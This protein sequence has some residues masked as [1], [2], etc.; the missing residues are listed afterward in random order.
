MKIQ[1]FN[2]YGKEETVNFVYIYK[3]CAR[4][5]VIKKFNT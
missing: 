3:F 5:I 4:K 1:F 2:F